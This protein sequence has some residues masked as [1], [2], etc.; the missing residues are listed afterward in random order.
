MKVMRYEI[1]LLKKIRIEHPRTKN[2]KKTKKNLQST[3]YKFLSNYNR[4]IGN[5]ITT[6]FRCYPPVTVCICVL[7]CFIRADSNGGF[8]FSLLCTPTWYPWTHLL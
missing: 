4:L 1:T 5:R 6:I 7:Y 8:S 2:K 3:I